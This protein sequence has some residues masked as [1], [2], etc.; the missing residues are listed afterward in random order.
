ME[1]HCSNFCGFVDQSLVINKKMSWKKESAMVGLSGLSPREA[2]RGALT[3]LDFQKMP[4]PLDTDPFSP[5]VMKAKVMNTLCSF[6][7]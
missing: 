5:I 4:D 1:S 2:A 7:F 6:E 3:C